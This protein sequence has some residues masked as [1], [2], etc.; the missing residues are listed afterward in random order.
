LLRPQWH[1]SVIGTIHMMTSCAAA[2]QVSVPR[3]TLIYQLDPPLV[4]TVMRAT[5]LFGVV[6]LYAI[7]IGLWLAW[8]RPRACL[9]TPKTVQAG[10]RLAPNH[11]RPGLSSIQ[12]R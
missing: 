9:Q 2:G 11:V 4:L 3:D 6:V 10:R 8:Q 12:Y 5:S 7:H 1:D